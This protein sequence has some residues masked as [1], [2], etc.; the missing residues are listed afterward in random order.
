MYQMERKTAKGTV[1][2]VKFSIVECNYVRYIKISFKVY[3]T[4]LAC[5]LCI[6]KKALFMPCKCHLNTIDAFFQELC[7][8]LSICSIVLVYGYTCN[9]F[10]HVI[11][12]L[13]FDPVWFFPLKM[14]RPSHSTICLL[15]NL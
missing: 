6:H 12:E 9:R 15:L 8:L 5:I 10:G 13:T 4:V 11:N 1:E 7:I 14:L 3:C 2:N